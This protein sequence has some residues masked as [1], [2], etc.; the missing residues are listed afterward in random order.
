MLVNPFTS[1]L[2]REQSGWGFTVKQGG[3]TAPEDSLAVAQS[4]YLLYSCAD[5][6]RRICRAMA[7]LPEWQ[8]DDNNNNNI[9]I[10]IIMS[11]FLE[12]LSM[13]NVL[14]CAEQVQVQKYKTHAYKTLTIVGVQIIML[15]HPTKHKKRMPI[16]PIYCINI[17]KNNPSHTN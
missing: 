3:R 17:R 2:A 1:L 12:R 16:K 6:G 8:K 4:H 11:V 10:I 5:G 7:G 9:I 13:W 14:N 15:K